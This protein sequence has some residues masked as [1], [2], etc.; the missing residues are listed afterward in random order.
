MSFS[1]R[2]E[3]EYA[4]RRRA[5]WRERVEG[6]QND[7]QQSAAGTIR[8]ALRVSRLKRI[9]DHT[10]EFPHGVSCDVALLMDK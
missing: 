3:R 5:D 7:G 4:V 2:L 8:R 9:L 1:G 6:V 10:L